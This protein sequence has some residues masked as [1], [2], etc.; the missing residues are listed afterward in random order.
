[1]LHKPIRMSLWHPDVTVTSGCHSDIRMGLWQWAIVTKPSGWVCGSQPH[2]HKPIHLCHKPIRLCKKCVRMSPWHPADVAVT[3]GC[4]RD[5][6]RMPPW[7]PPDAAVTSGWVRGT[8]PSAKWTSGHLHCHRTIHSCQADVRRCHM[9]VRSVTWCCLVNRTSIWQS[10]I[11]KWT[12]TCQ[13]CFAHLLS[14]NYS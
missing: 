12:S 4:H 9:D 1:M 11:V 14:A 5:I 10:M 8:N 13:F 3:S 2:C 7:H 6:R